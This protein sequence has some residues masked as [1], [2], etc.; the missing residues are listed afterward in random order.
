MIPGRYM[1]YAG[2]SAQ[3]SNPLRRDRVRESKWWLRGDWYWERLPV[4][5]AFGLGGVW[6]SRVC[7]GS[8]HF[9]LLF[10]LRADLDQN[11]CSA[12][13]RYGTRTGDR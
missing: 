3:D 2:V 4:R 5:H 8:P 7:V 9:E 11:P 12:V 1:A 6:A 10:F 13:M